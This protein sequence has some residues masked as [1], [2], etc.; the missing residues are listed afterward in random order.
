MRI[1]ANSRK[2]LA[3]ILFSSHQSFL[4]SLKLSDAKISKRI[5]IIKTEGKTR[6]F[7]GQSFPG[8]L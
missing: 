1:H 4:K 7:F 2:I 5:D 3:K 6:I 8:R